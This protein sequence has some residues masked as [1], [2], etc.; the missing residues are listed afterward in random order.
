LID[1]YNA[2]IIVL[3]KKSGED[4][5]GNIVYPFPGIGEEGLPEGKSLKDVHSK[6]PE[7][8]PEK[9]AKFSVRPTQKIPV[10]PDVQTQNKQQSPAEEA[11]DDDDLEFETI[12]QQS[13]TTDGQSKK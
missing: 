9:K 1:E 6:T 2:A 11:A 10:K 12:N 5:A 7:K 4:Y 8:Q 13:S 3:S